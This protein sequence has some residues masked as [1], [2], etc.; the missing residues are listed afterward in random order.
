MAHAV[1]VP[2]F[3][4]PNM[5]DPGGVEGRA[6]PV[7]QLA[8]A[9][10]QVIDRH[11]H[12]AVARQLL[13][14]HGV[15]ADGTRRHPRRRP[16]GR[17]RQRAD[18]PAV[19]RRLIAHFARRQPAG[20]PDTPALDGLAGREREILTLVGLGRSNTEIAAELHL[21]AATAKTC[22]S[23]LLGKLGARDRVQLVITAYESGLVGRS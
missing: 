5:R 19:T 3:D 22:I 10:A 1:A 8:E 21:A 7:R 20:P 2:P 9:V 12:V 4:Q 13:H 16:G 23:R 6:E 11:H 15:V 14:R 18:R 17:R